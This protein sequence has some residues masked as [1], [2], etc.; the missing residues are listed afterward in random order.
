MK[1]SKFQHFSGNPPSE[2]PPSFKPQTN[3]AAL[4]KGVGN[5]GFLAWAMH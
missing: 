3:F 1:K 5:L 2:D 4:G